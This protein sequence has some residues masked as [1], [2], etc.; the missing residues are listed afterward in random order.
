M[1]LDCTCTNISIEKWKNLMHGAY[2]VSYSNLLKKILKDLPD[3]YFSMGLN[4]Y[5]PYHERC[6]QTKTHYILVCSAIE[7][8]IKK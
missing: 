1:F 4:F 5:N 7:Y 8:F 2:K 6:K 3:F